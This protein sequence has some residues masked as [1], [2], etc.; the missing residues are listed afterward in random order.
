MTIA[1]YELKLERYAGPLEKLL[2]LIE[3]R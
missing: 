3:A 2:E 1:P